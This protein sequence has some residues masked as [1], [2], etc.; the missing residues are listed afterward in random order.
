MIQLLI[1][2]HHDL[3]RLG[4]ESRLKSVVG[5]KIVGSTSRYD[6]ALS[7]AKTLQPDVILVESKAPEGLPTLR[8]LCRALPHCAILVLTSYPDSR[9]EDEVL[10]MG[11]T[12]YLLKTLDTKALVSEIRTAA[13][14]AQPPQAEQTVPTVQQAAT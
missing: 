6:T 5:L 14:S 1:I 4:L 13:R 9:E 7:Q 10:Q 3:V 8:A 2:D 12:R 11:V